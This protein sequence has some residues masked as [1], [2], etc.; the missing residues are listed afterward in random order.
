[1]PSSATGPLIF[2]VVDHVHNSWLEIALEVGL[3]GALALGAAFL[4]PLVALGR[5][6]A[7][8]ELTPGSAACGLL[9]RRSRALPSWTRGIQFEIGQCGYCCRHFGRRLGQPTRLKKIS[10]SR[11]PDQAASLGRGLSH[12]V[13]PKPP[14]GNIGIASTPRLPFI[15]LG[16]S[17]LAQ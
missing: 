16:E 5:R 7:G 3:V 6:L 8:A 11:R 12:L 15:S 17:L 10:G 14:S 9:R 13:S 2:A 4:A 1:M